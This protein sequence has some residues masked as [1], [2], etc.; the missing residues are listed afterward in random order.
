MNAILNRLGIS[1]DV[2][3]PVDQMQ[4]LTSRL[5]DKGRVHRFYEKLVMALDHLKVLNDWDCTENKAMEAWHWVFQHDFWNSEEAQ[6]SISEIGQRLS[7]AAL[8]GS[9]YVS[10]T[11]KVTTGPSQSAVKAPSQRFY[12]EN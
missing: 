10:P 1:E 8:S 3:N 6:E 11:G 9:L 5:V 2:Y 7:Q 4:L 12:G